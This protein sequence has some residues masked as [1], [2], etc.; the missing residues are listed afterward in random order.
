MN[1]TK[2]LSITFQPRRPSK[3]SMEEQ[4]ATCFGGRI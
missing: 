2:R 3:I 4:R 1:K